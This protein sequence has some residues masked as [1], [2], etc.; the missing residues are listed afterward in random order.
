MKKMLLKRAIVLALLVIVAISVG[1][2]SIGL[3][4]PSSPQITK[5]QPATVSLAMAANIDPEKLY[6]VTDV[7]DGDTFKV[8]INNEEITVRML[9]INTPE[10]VDPRKSVECFG[11][12]ASAETKS[13]LNS[14]EV[15]LVLNPNRE[16][17]DIYN[18]LLA[19]VYRDDGLF[20]NGLLIQEGFAREY[21][22]GKAY[23]FQSEFKNVEK[24][25]KVAKKGLWGKCTNNE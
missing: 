1:Y 16:K 25:A 15:K 7:V 24:Q 9:G 3:N 18:R 19:Y 4:L 22:V 10:V 8:K 21:T 20:L 14:R 17:T 6:K 2:F 23:E 5:K 12:E 11:P 13:L